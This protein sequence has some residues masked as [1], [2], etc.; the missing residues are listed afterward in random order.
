MRLLSSITALSLVLTGCV[1]PPP[2]QPPNPNVT[3]RIV[4]ICTHSGFF[5][6]V[7]GIVS[8]AYPAAGL[9]VS[10]LDMGIDKVCM[11]PE[12]YSS[13]ISTVEWLLRNMPRQTAKPTSL[14]ER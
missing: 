8:T 1:S 10:L 14:H 4:E 7:N 6:V 13:D 11:N 12:K 2:A 9:P 5:K 3:K